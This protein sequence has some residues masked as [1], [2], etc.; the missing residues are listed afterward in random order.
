MPR[1][2]PPRS[3]SGQAHLLSTSIKTAAGDA[4]A[5]LTYLP[6]GLVA[7]ITAF[8]N[9]RIENGSTLPGFTKLL[10]QRAALEGNVTRETAEAQ[11]A[12][13]DLDTHIRDYIVVLAR[14]TYRMKHSVAVLDYHQ[15]DHD[16]NIPLITSREDRRTVALQLIDGDATAAAEGFP[17]MANP[18][19][20]ELQTRLTTATTETDQIVPADRALQDILG[21]IRE[22]RPHATELVQ[23][24]LDELRHATRRIE[25]GTARDIMRSY[26]V[27]F[28][29]L[30]GE[31]PEPGD[32]PADIPAAPAPPAAEEA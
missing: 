18:S 10:A 28:E 20:A 12:E 14:R 24:I 30:P 11:A 27:T 15:L 7:D 8:L 16:G 5:G 31:I 32:V 2:R 22:A 21:L 6:P 26:G 25:P 4:S 1:V 19:A 17:L 9:D 29:T 13:D 23:E 3:D